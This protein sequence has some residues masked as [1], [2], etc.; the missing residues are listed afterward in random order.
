MWDNYLRQ[1]FILCS[2]NNKFL[3]EICDIFG[4][5]L[6]LEEVEYWMAYSPIRTSSLH[7][8]DIDGL[9]YDEALIFIESELKKRKQKWQRK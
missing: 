7:D 4:D 2:N 9:S 5:K 1:L 3:Y 6:S 8:I